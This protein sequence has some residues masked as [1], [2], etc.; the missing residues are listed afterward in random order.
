MA[1]EED[2]YSIRDHFPRSLIYGML[3]PVRGRYPELYLFSLLVPYAQG[4]NLTPILCR[5]LC[6]WAERRCPIRNLEVPLWTSGENHQIHIRR[7]PCGAP[8]V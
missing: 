4:R 8:C 7:G 5:L 3:Y 2:P 6:Y 1:V